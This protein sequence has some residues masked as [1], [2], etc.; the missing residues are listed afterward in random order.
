MTIRNQHFT[1][2]NNHHCAASCA[3][4]CTIPHTHCTQVGG[5]PFPR[6]PL[7]REGDADRSRPLLGISAWLSRFAGQING[8]K[9]MGIRSDSA[10]ASRAGDNSTGQLN[11]WGYYPDYNCYNPLNT[12]AR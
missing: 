5:D 4:H 1:N 12:Q 9:G 2:L 11:Q 7:D 6:G 10:G 8:S 3:L